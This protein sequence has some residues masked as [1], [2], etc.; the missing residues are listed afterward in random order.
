MLDNTDIVETMLH[1]SG[2]PDALIVVTSENNPV[3]YIFIAR[4]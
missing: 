1:V 4:T 3:P 2:T